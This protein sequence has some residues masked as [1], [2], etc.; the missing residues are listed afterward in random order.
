[1]Y[2][3]T[4]FVVFD[5]LSVDISPGWW[6]RSYKF[7]SFNRDYPAVLAQYGNGQWIVKNG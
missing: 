4:F 5:F 1:M 7:S 2:I 6:Y 3:Y